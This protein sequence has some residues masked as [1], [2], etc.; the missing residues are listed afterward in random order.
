MLAPEAQLGS[1]EQKIQETMRG[2]VPGVAFAVV[3]PEAICTGALGTADLRNRTAESPL[4]LHNWFSMT[5]AMTAAAVMQLVEK[6]TIRLDDLACQHC[7]SLCVVAPP[8]W[9][10]RITIRHL[11]THAS[12]LSNPTSL[13]WTHAAGQENPYRP[14]FLAELLRKNPKLRFEPGTSA[15]YSNL[16]YLILGQVI[17]HVTGK[18][19]ADYVREHILQPLKMN[20]TDFSHVDEA[21]ATGYQAKWSPRTSLMRLVVP[22]GVFGP[23][24]GKYVSFNRLTADGA[25]FDGLIGPV[26]DAARFLQAQLRGGELDGERI[27]SADSVW[28]MQKLLATG[29]NRSFGM[30]WFQRK[31]A[32]SDDRAFLENVGKGEGFRNDMRIYPEH[33]M[34]ILLMGNAS[35]YA[36]EPIVDILAERYWDELSA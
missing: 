23:P 32:P 4:M 20:R 8:Q 35:D 33:R 2:K 22:D 19:Y 31:A 16:G 17:S 10:E 13:A 21:A 3:S 30:G 11:L 36:P 6:G 5:T 26:S 18:S 12:G 15:K 34:A 25:A 1:A 28:L 14:Y 24:E 9:A 29:K 7:P 27:L